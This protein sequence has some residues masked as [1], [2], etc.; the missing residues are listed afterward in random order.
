MYKKLLIILISFFLFLLKISLDIYAEDLRLTAFRELELREPVRITILQPA[1]VIQTLNI[2]PG[3]SILDIGAGTGLFTFRFAKALKG[4]GEVFATDTDSDM[5]KYIKEMAGEGKY[6]NVFP[7][8]VNREG[9]DLFYKQHSFD[10]IFLSE[11]YQDMRRHEDYFR[12]LRPSLKKTGRLYILHLKN[13]S[14]FSKFEF[15][16]FKKVIEVLFSEGRGFPV[17]QRLRPEVQ[18][19][20]KNWQGD[21]KEVPPEIRRKIVEDFNKMLSDRLLFHDLETYKYPS[22]P[23]ILYPPDIQLAKWLTVHMNENGFFDR[24]QL[25]LLNR[26]LLSGIFQIDK[27]NGLK[28]WPLVEKS[29]I[30][31]I[32]KAAGYQFVREHDFL[33][34]YF[35]LEFKRK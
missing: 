33:R 2:K 12:K 1:R 20:I 34:Q 15:D 7:V 32:L 3:M 14:N 8:L 22:L 4:T 31:S 19:F 28:G 27:L 29:S 5:I 21:D 17:F 18:S 35:F 26:I 9:I 16:D 11:V 13:V 23:T 10:I 25:S 24:K 30:I 6:K